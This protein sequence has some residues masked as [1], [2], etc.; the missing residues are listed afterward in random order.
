MP[1]PHAASSLVELLRLRAETDPDRIAYTFLQNGEVEEG[2]VT[3]GELDLRARAVAARLQGLGAR[4]ERALLLY[5]PGLEYVAALFGCFY[6]GVTAV[7]AYPPRR[8]KTDPRLQAIV[9]DCAPTLALATR[10]LLGEAERL[11]AHTPE[12]G[13]LRWMATEDAPADEAEGWA[14]PEATGDTLAFL[15]YTSGSTAAP[16]GVMVSHGNL[17]HNF[18]VIERLAGYTPQ[19]R[20]VIWLPPYHDMGLIGG[21]LQPLFTGYWAALFSPVAFIQRP[22]RWLEAVSRYGATSSGG[23][24]FAYELCVHAVRPEEREG[25]DLSYWEIAFNGAEPVRAETLR[26]FA[27]SFAPSGFRARAFYP[28]YGLAEATLMVTGS[29]PAELAVERAVDPEAL[30]GGAVVADADP[31]G[32]YRL[33]GSGRSAESQRVIVVDPATLRECAPDRVGEVWVAG[34]SVARGY[35]GRAEETAETFGAF[36]AGTGEGPFLRTG[37]LGFLEDG[38]LFVTGRLKDLIVIRGRN[39]YPQDVEQTAVRSHP[40]L[41]AG[42]GAAFSIDHAGEERL[43][44]VQE[45]S[46]QA[47]AGLDVEE[48]A[49]AVRRAV[50]AE[51]GVQVHA[52]AV[53]RPGGVPRTSSGKVQ[54]RACRALFLAGELPLVGVSV[55]EDAA[56]AAP[57][58]D[59]AGLTR[60]ALEAAAAEERQELLEGLLVERA[61]QVL[62]LDPAGVDRAQPLVAL[63]LDSLRAMEL[64]GALEAGLGTQVPVSSLLDDT[65][66]DRLA[67]ELLQAMFLAEPAA[68]APVEPVDGECPLSFAQER[69]WFLDRLQPGSAA[70][71]LSGALRLRGAVDAAALRRSLREI[72]RRHDTLRTVFAEAGGRPVQRVLAAA[73]VPLPEVDLSR[74]DPA[75][76]GGAVRRAAADAG[77][78]PFDLETGPPFRARLLRLAADEHLLVMGMHHVVSDGW[79][80]GVLIR[81]LGALYPAMLAGGESPLP[82]LPTQYGDWALRQRAG[83]HGEAAGE[84]L[85]YWRERLA[86]LQALDL[87]TDHPRPHVQSFRGAT[88]RF[89][90]P[91]E[92]MRGVRALAR[93]EGATLFM[94]LLAAWDLLLARYAGQGDVAVGTS[95]SNRDRAEV[96]GLVG[97][98]VNTLVLRVEVV[99]EESFRALLARARAAALEAF[100][101]QELPFER[102]VEE[103]HPERDLSRN[104]L[105]QV[106]LAPQNTTL[107]PVE[108]PGATL[109]PEPLDGGA[110]ILDLTLYTWER[111]GGA[112]A[113]ALEYAT[114]LFEADTARRMA[115]HLVGVLRAVAA[116]PG[117]AVAEVPLL[118]PAERARVLEEW[119][120]T[121]RAYPERCLHE[122]FAEAAAR[123]PDAAAVR[124]GGHATRYAELERSANRLAHH[125]RALGVGPESRVGLCV[126]RT[127]DMLAAMLGI[128]GAGGAYVPLDPAYPAE[129]LAYMLEDAGAAVVVAQAHLAERLPAG[130]PRVLLDAQAERIAAHPDTAPGGGAVPGNLA[131]VLYTSGSTGRPKGV[132][133]EHRSASQVV[134][135]LRDAVRAEDRAAVLGSTSVSF[136][137][138]VGEIFGTLCWGGTLVLVENVL[139]LPRVAEEGVRLVVTVPGALMELLRGGGV[140]E[141]VRA[142]NL[143]GEALP[144]PLARELYALPGTERVLNLYG[145]TEDTVYS[146][147]SEVE[148]GAERVRIGRPVANS[149]AYV[150][151]PAGSPAPVGVAGELCLG[152]A[153]VARGYHRRPGLTA[154]RFVPDP[155]SARPGARMYRTGDRARWLAGG[156]LEYL[157]RIDGQVKVRGFRIEPGEVESALLEHPGVGD[158]VV[159]PRPDGGGGVRLVAYH[160]AAEGEARP[161]AAELRAWLRERLP[162]YMVPSGFVGLDAF[163]LTPSGKVDRRALP[164]PEVEG[165]GE[166]EPARPSTPV[167]EILAGI[168]AAVLGVETVGIHDDFFALGGH[169]L[170]GAR[171]V[172]RIR[173]A[174][175]VELPL[176]ALFEAPTVAE[177]AGR[178]EALRGDGSALVAPPVERAARSGPLPLSFAQQRLWVVDQLDPGSP[179]YNMPLALRLRGALDAAVL[180][181]CVGE[182][183]RR[184]E[185]LRTVFREHG[186]SPVQ[187]VRPPAGV[188]LPVLD[189]RGLPEEAR[190]GR[191]RRL[192]EEEAL[193]P[194]DLARGPLL[195]GTLLRLGAEDHVLCFTMH[196]VVGDGWST[197]IMVRELSA[198]YGAFGRGEAS[199]LPELPVQYA[200]FA[201]WQRE[202]L[203]GE[204]LEAQVGFWR[205]RLRGAPPLLEVPLDRPR[206]LARDARAGSHGFTL[207]PEVARRLR[208]LSRREGATLFMTAL[209]GWQALLARYAGQ[210]DV[211][212]GTPVAGR[213]RVETEGVVGFFVNMLALRADLGGEPT[214]TELLGRVRE[215]TLGAYAHQDLPFERLVDELGVERSLAH[216]PLFQVVFALGRSAPGD[217]LAL[218]GL[219]I[220]RFAAGGEAAKFDLDLR[221]AEEGERLGGTLLFRESLFEAATAARMAGHLEVLLGA[222]A[223]D[224]AR[225][226]SEV[227]L[228]LGAERAQVLAASR[229][230]A[231][232]RPPA[233]VH[234]LFAEQAARTPDRTAVAGAGG[235][236]SYADLERRSNRLAH[237]LRALGVGPEVRVG[238]CLERTPELVVG[239]LGVLK[240]GGAYVPLDPSYPAER[241]EYALAD[242]GAA[243]LVTQSALLGTLAGQGREVLCLDRDR[244]AAEGEAERAP[245]SG[246]GPR[247]AAYVIYTS[248]STGRPKGVV[249]EHGGLLNL[250]HWH[251][252]AFAV[253]ETDRATQLAGLGFDASVWELWPYLASGA[254]VHL[255]ADEET[256][257]SPAALR[258]LLLDERITVAFAPTPTAEALLA[259]EWPA[260]APLR[261][262]LTGGDALRS[263]PRADL[264]FALVNNYGPT[265]N[266]VVATSGA[267]AAGQGSG[268]APGIGRP[269]DNVQAY[270]L[271]SRHGP[272]PAGVAGE[273][274]VGG[275][276]V[277]RGYLGRAG[278]TAGSFVP[279][280]FGG[281]PG[282][283]LYRTGDRVRRR[284]DGELEFL[285]RVDQQ[286][287]IRGFRIEPGEVEA[288]LA[289]HPRV[290]EAVVVVREDLPGRR[291]LVAYVVTEAGAEVPAAELRERAARRLPEY[292]VPAAFVALE[293]LPLNPSGKTDRRALP[294]PEWGGGA[295]PVAPR[296]AV[297]EAL[298]AVWAEVLGVERVGVEDGFFELGGDSILSIQ[299]VSRARQRGLKLTP[300]QLFEHPTVARLAEVVERVDEGA[301]AA[302]E[303][304]TGEAP[305][306]PIQQR[307][308]E[309]A[310]PVPGHFNQALL[311]VPRDG[312]DAGLLARAASALEA[313]H[314]AL[315]LRFRRDEGGAWRQSHAAAGARSPLAVFDLSGLP[316]T[317]RRGAMEAAAE[318]VQRS[319]ELGRGPLLRMAYFELGAG[320]AG[321][322]LVVV[323]HLAVDGVSWR[324]LLEDLETA[325]AQLS[326]G[327]AVR[328]P[329]KTTSYKAWAERLAEHARTKAIAGEAEYWAAQAARDVPLLPTDGP[330]GASTESRSRSVAVR[331]GEE[332]TE[333]LLREVPQAY[334]TQI[335]EVLLTALAAA[336]G[337][338]TGS[339]R[340]RIDLEGHGREEE[341]VGGADLSRTV[342]WFTTVYPVVLELPETGGAGA[343]LK[344][345]KEQLRAVPG[346]G[347]GWGLLRWLGGGEAAAELAGAGEPE[348]AF[349]YLGQFDRSVSGEAFFAF[350]EE[351]AGP[352]AD[353]STPRRHLLEVSGAV[354][355]GRLELEVG[356]AEGVHRRETVERLA[357]SYAAE[358]RG[359]IAH[360]TSDGAGGWTPSDFPLAR[361]E[362]AELDALLGNERGVEDV[363]P[364][365]PMQEGMLFHAL[366]APESGVYV[367]QFGFAMEG[368]LDADAL[369]RAWQGALARHDALRAGFAWEGVPRPLQVVR[370]EARLPFLR[371]D[372]RGLDEDERRARLERWLEADRAAGFELGRAPLMRLALFRLGEETHQ[373]VWTHHHLVL[374]G[375]SLSLI[376]RDVLALY[377]SHAGGSA[378]QAGAAR[379]YREYV[380]WLGR[381]DR[382]RAE[383]FWR[384]ALA[385]FG[386]PTPLPGARARR[387]A[388]AGHGVETLRLGEGATEAL[389]E[390]A[391]RLGVTL[392][393]LVQGAWALLLSRYAGEEDV[394]FGATVSGRP[395]ELEGVEE[396]VGL[397]INTLPVRVRLPGEA[398]L[399]E[400]LAGVQR[401]QAE[402]REFEYA[403]LA[404]V[405]RWSEVAAGEELFGSLVVYENYPVGQALAEA[406]RLKG[407]RVRYDAARQQTNYPLALTADPHGELKVHLRYE[408]AAVD[409]AAARRLL[410][411]LEA[412]FQALAA[413][414]ELRLHGVSLLRTE[415]RAHLLHAWNGADEGYTGELCIHELVRAQVLRTPA[416]PALRF[417]SQ[418]LGYEELFRAASRLAHR[419][420]RE[421]V[422]PEARVGICME[423]APEMIVSVLGVLLAGGAYLP[424]DPELPAERRDYMLRDA[425]P[426]LLLT[427]AAL[428]PRLEGCGVPL[429]PVDAEAGRI[430]A[431][432][433]EAPAGGAGPDNLAYVIYTSGSTGRPKGVLVEHRGV[434]NTFL[435]LGRV[436]G[437]GPGERSLAYA[438]LHF[439]ASV[440][441]IFVALCNGAELVLARSEAMLPGDDLVRLLREQRI[442]HL[443]TMPSALAVTPVEALPELRTI[444]TGGEVCPAE[445]VR[446]WGAGRRFFNGY[447]ATEAS[448]RMTSSAYTGEGGDPP[449]GHPVAN[450]QL[451]VLDGELEP[452]PAG[453]P[454]EL[455]IGGVGVVRGYLGRPDLTA[456]RFV[457]DPHRGVAGARLYR[458]GDVGRRRAD[459]EVE[460]LGRRDHQVKVR[461]YRVELGEIE[462]VLR[463][464]AGV[465]EA[466]V[467]LWE[468]APGRQR[469]AAYVSARAGAELSRAELR[470]HAAERLPEYMVPSAV[471]VLE[472]LPVTPNGKIDRRAL[473]APE[474][475]GAEGEYVAPRTAAEEALAAVWAEVLGLERVGVEEGFFE[476]GGDSILSIQVVSRARRRGLKLTPRQLFEN[477]TVARLAA[478]AG[479]TG[480]EAGGPAQGPVTGEAPLTPAQRRFF[481]HGFAARHHFN[482]GLLLAPRE[483]LDAGLLGRAAAAVEAHHDA[484]RLRFRQDPEGAWR[485]WHAPVGEGAPPLA[486]LDLSGLAEADRRRAIETA[487]EQVQR[488]LDPERG[489]LLR[490]AYFDPG[491]GEAGRLLGV[492]HHLAV[493]AVSWRI[494]LEDLETAYAQLSRGEAV[495][496]PAKTTSYKAWAERLAGHA[497]SEA[498]AA[499]AEFW[500]GQA[501]T[502]VAA[503]PVDDAAGENRVRDARRVRV[504]LGEE[505]TGALLRE[506]PQAY[507]TQVDE[508]LLTALAAA[509]ARWT[510]ERRVRVELE[511]H[512]REELFAEVDLSRTVGW[513]TSVYPVVLELPESGGAGAA[514]KAVKEQL[515]AVPGR[516]IGY[517]L[518][519]Y[520]ADP[521]AAAELARG[522]RPQVGFNYLGQFDRSVSAD[523]FFAFAPE[524][525]GAAQDGRS[526]R[527]Y[528]LDVTGAVRDGCLELEVG[529]AEGVHRR[530]TV[531]RL[532]QEFAGELRGLIAHCTSDGAG[533]WTLSDFPL[534]RLEQAELDALL[535]NERGVEDVFPLSPLQEGIL[536]HALYAPESGVYVGQFGQ[537]LEGPLDA[538]ALERAWQ[539]A[540]A[541]HDALR[542]GFAWEGVPRP[543]QVVRREARLPFLREDWRGLDEDERRARLE[544]WLEADRAAGFELGR[545]P[546]M[547]LALFRL[548]EETHQLV[549]THHHLVLDGWSL[550]LIFRDVLALYAS[551]AGGSAPQAG[552][553]RRYREYVAW[554]GRQDRARAEAFWRGALAGFGAPTPLP[555]ARAR[556]GAEAGHGVETLRLGEGATEALR[557]QARRLGVT[558]GT[559][560]QGAWALLLSRYAGEEDV[561]FG[562]TVSGR[563][564]ELEGVEETV[565]LFI[566]T[567][568]VRVRLPGEARLGEW[569]AGVQREQAEAREFEYA[570]LAEVRRWSEVAAGEELFGS[571]VVYENYPVDQA[572]A[573]RADRLG[574]LRLGGRFGHQQTSYPLVLVAD[575]AAGAELK[576]ELRYERAALDGEGARRLLGHLETV[577]D[578]IAGSP[579]R[580]LSEVSLLRGE[581]WSRLRGAPAAPAAGQGAACLHELFSAQAARTPG[582]AAVSLGDE[583]LTYA[584]LERRA[585]RL[586][587]HL[588]RR[589]VG[590]EARV[591]VC[592][593]RSSELIVAL[594]AVLKAGGAYVPI[595]PAYPAERIAYLLE[596]SGCAAVL[597]QEHLRGLLGAA[598][599]DVLVLEDALADAGGGDAAPEVEVDPRNAAYVIYTSGSTG[600]PKGV[601][602]THG[603]VARLFDATQAWFGFGSQD[604]WTLFHSYAFDF[605][606]WEI[607]G[608]LLHGGRLVV[609]PW[610]TSRDPEA[611]H[612]LLASER[613][614]VLNQTPSAFRQLAA[615]EEERG[616]S[617][618]LALR[619]VVFGGEALEPGSLRGW[620]RRHGE[621]RPLLVNMYGITETTVHVTYRPVR[622]ADVE[623]GERSPVGE[624]IPDLSVRVLDRWGSPVPT[625]VPGELYVGGAGVSRGYLGRPELTAERFVPDP[626]G[627]ES[628]ARLYRSGD[629]A[630]WLAEGELEYLGRTD[631]QVKIRGFRIE[632]GE[633]E[634]VLCG[635]PGVREA[636]VTVR[637]DA[638]GQKRLVG[639]VAPE[640]GADL[641]GEEL[642][643][644]LSARLPEHMVPAAFV[645]LERLPLNA[646]GKTDRRALPAPETAAAGDAF[647]A[648]R[649][650]VEE[651]LAG[652]WAEVLG[653]ERVGV[654]DGFF[655]L[656]G[657]SI[658]SIQVVSRARQRGLKLTPRQL[659]EQPTVARLAAVVERV[660]EGAGAAQEPVT[661]EAPLTPIQH[662][663]FERT[664]PVPGHFN[665]ALLLVP[666]ARLD[667]GPL[668]RAAS[669]LE[670]HHDALRL[671]FARDEGG[672]WRQR[673]AAVGARSPLAV[674]DLSGLPETR[675]RGAMEAAAERVQR[676]LE[677]ERGPL[678]RMAY[679]DPGADLP[680][681]L[682]VVIHHLAVDGVS[683]RILLEDL[684]SAYAQLSRGEAARL[685]AKT[686]SWRAWAERLAEHARSAA[687]AGEAA[688]WVGQAR[689]AAAALPTDGP[690]GENTVAASR[691]VELRLSEEETEA[692]LREVPQAYRTQIDE[693]LLTALAAALGRWTGSRRVRID[694]EGHGR[695]EEAVGGA[696]LSRTVGWFTT[697]YP[698]V[699]ELPETGGAGAALK[700]VKEQLRAVPGKGIGYGLLRWLGGG[701]A[702]AELAGAAEPG[703]AFNYLGQFD[704]SVSGESFF[705]FAEESAGAP[706]DGSTPRRHLLEVSGAVRGGRLELKVGYAEG[707]Y[708]PET[709]E[710]LAEGYGEELRALI[711]HC[712]SE[713]AGG[714]TPSDFPLVELDDETLAFLE[715]EFGEFAEFELDET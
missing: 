436:Y 618:E 115:A 617:A 348:V 176:R 118:L 588:R 539:G 573:E 350:A 194:F 362:Q 660:D 110:A 568:P 314:D 402:A 283:R 250:V 285:G 146:T 252:A 178:V 585:N 513:F 661:G 604:V 186:G 484:L 437:V 464:H 361:L 490:M 594:L 147:W 667:A 430:A 428:A 107:E 101:R 683:W 446:R 73:A 263:R 426:V 278:A 524:S 345:V 704:Q 203:G 131:Y 521:G 468:D 79:S 256:R 480:R 372:W 477:P 280:A 332:E 379:R 268:R 239:V 671:R 223:A 556:R 145:P 143:A 681:R 613:V 649:S 189:L 458:T 333:A 170:L 270:V 23:P 448:I 237:R 244:E 677:L 85:T 531:E 320:L 129:R 336:L 621:N 451:Y 334:R 403:P 74:L 43:V 563:P 597:V 636:V 465:R 249:V 690:A 163:P 505:E 450:T 414:P 483:P 701:G 5:P 664:G 501:R 291:R 187:V 482:Q 287:K 420:R 144:A 201:V 343:A 293:R 55:R 139:D 215:E 103:L 462:A 242:S 227:S 174:F 654:E 375:W 160:L 158:A 515:R 77:R 33:V 71:N 142:F 460:F 405:R 535:G 309:R 155:F 157:G 715:G 632:P 120:A 703:V 663:F 20:S 127:P 358:L 321:R 300:R 254:A 233:C 331:L 60:E 576:A 272:V 22:A 302:Q 714:Y 188:E 628:G 383:A 469:L 14:D 24:N 600:R 53:V 341:A 114:D 173:V 38:E 599:A 284:A 183:V 615:V 665:H 92:V 390:Q 497:R 339:R 638:P 527:R 425:A 629:R 693:V 84:Q 530:E 672:A 591:G 105:F 25:L 236:L 510:G 13:G 319:L 171:V 686:T 365:S 487:A 193:R 98:F 449:I 136:D 614:T 566:N 432:S 50:A 159:A 676:S 234:E 692:L 141:S 610:E 195:R 220:E 589:G 639:Y 387:G 559:L 542:A 324:I 549:W 543:L 384:G 441:D 381:Q 214:W 153:G 455:Y 612:R 258:A 609:V 63:G 586:A 385:G 359:L 389:R 523:A 75:E 598:P 656:G 262:L 565:G 267:V 516:G 27:E 431:E 611:F 662:R 152:G 46:R 296:T 265:E 260:D 135:F 95:V 388:E 42:S 261:L 335:D 548:G 486:A 393:T 601:V 116:D 456:E 443:K 502:L 694:L 668:A 346:K 140:P 511:G 492:V 329:A 570:P 130:V 642:R 232:G 72:V 298:A 710:R 277:A 32:K 485:Q 680:G 303:P 251:R 225:R 112:L 582:A 121:G 229:G 504:R 182:L 684:E 355:G 21:I 81:E 97:L 579:E 192:A 606:V 16:K 691:S 357:E 643:E 705:A 349:N 551:H 452:V 36:E 166:A 641:T 151:D 558:L 607:W 26:A 526:T 421:G 104:P 51:H 273:L 574:G 395:A 228:L 616:A 525:A 392:G 352:P 424:L 87:P 675:R 218:G 575:A 221:L 88:H 177:L 473:P 659:F 274:W 317:R 126:E 412:A 264:P 325:Y 605:S 44:V 185:A 162:D 6:A 37:D 47:A 491:A 255:V 369:E 709:V 94:A 198:L 168:W 351:S 536:F 18:A 266:T 217:H 70:Y 540:L 247:S 461:G 243:V 322:L 3:H 165:A 56:V 520:L 476:L 406:G 86:G 295:E 674:F 40:G 29:R 366:Y 123:T 342:G 213:T 149:R 689:A 578:A 148:R 191:A 315:R 679:F 137:V 569:L 478:V 557:E 125:L 175:E 106:M 440:A 301:G 650:E 133:V 288:A 581:E 245:R 304:V 651:T 337:R 427:Q 289:E 587:H 330:R 413:P 647:V 318:R 68:P 382:A 161:A 410:G 211:V 698:V 62:G 202:W 30:G 630:R 394:V 57:R 368:P 281:E 69:L 328:L 241:L 415:E 199:P 595:D 327:G 363:F 340:V 299:V 61:A 326:R 282:A 495:V 700:A 344:A 555:G 294:A 49:D 271:D 313:H 150:L 537:V 378:P 500:A 253:T 208:A 518:L 590:P 200:D 416:A 640:H 561:V 124:F 184:H 635:H 433:G 550:S 696:D 54:R 623:A 459:G 507:R 444:V 373:L 58:A 711:A 401:E 219:E 631:A 644:H 308:F 438:P 323:H 90:V 592:A 59:S 35:W 655:E 207:S 584:E 494:L 547:R 409:A 76:R 463:T 580:R 398:R 222:M 238:V 625:G 377:A 172:S 356:Y 64:K 102:L 522:P 206:T 316:E 396:T 608:A 418:S 108:V 457:P 602:V 493:D 624:A 181:A 290:R 713:E 292:M 619:V 712:R 180:R 78:V 603:N 306:T 541:R 231:V 31:E 633:I 204:T 205:E 532:A 34:P 707:V 442:T 670:A 28:C 474:R 528:L 498:P 688:Y 673:H 48:V 399:G 422:G 311:L 489:P 9:A 408:R 100:T 132:Q 210:D 367:G 697:V 286:V 209:A 593:E 353:G 653:V 567:L 11:C 167:E 509:L 706:A 230:E 190:E 312:L 481:E 534:A 391:R 197:E 310:G 634:A 83:L 4:G 196:H 434:G 553:A 404:E 80:A 15:Q 512:G 417:E 687:L 467:L 122:L 435:E 488:S 305:P 626:F 66:I 297:E 699:L 552:A 685:P 216:T 429:L 164:E 39:H 447:G 1:N 407:L 380:A 652:I 259:L 111:S 67:A 224:P 648:P 637:E 702:A 546:L 99:P 17:L 371:E 471:V 506:V 400:W 246:A 82:P 2:H 7:P 117:L 622:W 354:R 519:R 496:L 169:S 470:E 657:D 370:R 708:R 669:A 12:L 577:L 517:G 96:A 364:L 514:L 226:L 41:R 658:L 276:G 545:A 89:E 423:R 678:L 475:G 645:V 562:A 445:Q 19:T 411:H 45:V 179:A 554:L 65:R 154:E 666:R 8:N 134:H 360:C 212:V 529:Y 113:A 646:N 91:A 538:D 374:D 508:V 439:D 109:F 156:E 138:S 93:A 307:F 376:F 560:V 386:A 347:I 279:D 596:D 235:T 620:M 257:T 275:A 454:G 52:V 466:A 572:L 128:L 269:I 503:L 695:E 453:V 119:N 248:G 627:G 479:W 472:R 571:L 583:T 240:A 397:F 10:E 564:A 499:E 338:W 544:R 682:L 419:L 533:G